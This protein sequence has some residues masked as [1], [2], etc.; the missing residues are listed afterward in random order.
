MLN[1]YT[2]HWGHWIA[3]VTVILLILMGLSNLPQNTAA[4]PAVAN[5]TAKA[6]DILAQVNAWRVEN[7]LWP[8]TVNPT[9]DA[10]AM[11]QASYVLPFLPNIQNEEQYHLDAKLRNPASAARRRAGLPTA[12]TLTGLKSVKTRVSARRSL[13]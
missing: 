11:A 8:L 1:T 10:L 5:D 13:S 7:G 2:R 4:Q 6:A 12:R 3:R 9:L